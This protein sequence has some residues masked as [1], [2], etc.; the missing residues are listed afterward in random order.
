M[1]E[2]ELHFLYLPMGRG[3]FYVFC[4]NL[5]VVKGGLW[6]AMSGLCILCIGCLIFYSNRA[7]AASLHELR[8][9]QY[10][11]AK[12]QEVFNTYDVNGDGCLAPTEY[13]AFEF[14]VV[15]FALLHK[16]FV[17]L[18][19]RLANLCNDLGSPLDYNTLESALLTLDV[20]ANGKI[21]YA[22]F[23]GWYKGDKM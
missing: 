15:V 17:H 23:I 14:F 12:I 8:A 21:S 5:L 11:D 18:M 7:A 19:F 6:S 3:V 13:V 20:D 9:Q 10:D 4:G 1:I 2:R 22:E 16:I